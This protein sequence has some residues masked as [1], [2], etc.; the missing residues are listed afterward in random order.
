MRVGSADTT[1][2][3]LPP[4]GAPKLVPWPAMVH[5]RSTEYAAH[6]TR[7]S[8]GEL[9]A[10]SFEKYFWPL[11]IKAVLRFTIAP[12]DATYAQSTM[13]MTMPRDAQACKKHATKDMY[14]MLHAESFR[15]IA[16]DQLIAA[17]DDPLPWHHAREPRK[18]ALV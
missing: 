13:P 11:V 10:K 5:V 18:E 8:H 4:A 1:S 3:A 12:R 15:D 2:R 9:S 6:T 17:E 7:E 16:G 14:S